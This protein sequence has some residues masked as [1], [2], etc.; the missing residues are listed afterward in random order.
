MTKQ[1]TRSESPAPRVFVACDLP[2]SV[3]ALFIERFS[4][5]CNDKRRTLTPSELLA[6]VQG[7]DVLVLTATDR[8]DG[9]L[10][11]Q[12]PASLKVICTYSI[13]MEHLDV[14]ALKARGIAVLA[15]PDV[16]NESCADVALLLMLGAARRVVES[17]ALVRTGEWKGWTPRQLLGVDFWGRRLGILGMGRI[18]RAIAKRARGFDMEIH[19]HNRSRLSADLELGAVHH[20]DLA[21]LAAHSDFLCVACPSNADTKGLVNADIISLLP[22]NAVVCNISRGDIIDDEA[23]IAALRSG[24]VAAAGLDVYTGEPNIH[25]AYRELPNVFGLPHIGSSTESTRLAM[26]RVLCDGIAAFYAGEEPANRV[27]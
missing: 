9:K 4:A 1:D 23:L 15:T 7:M 26:G 22:G 16:L 17:A 5:V 18:G 19:Y 14:D 12:L 6:G 24:A 21:S 3:Q 11:G 13:G 8:L 25:P 2:E 10:V 27:A 20:T